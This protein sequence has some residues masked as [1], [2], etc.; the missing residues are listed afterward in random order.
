MINPVARVMAAANAT[1]LFN[2]LLDTLFGLFFKDSKY[3]L[4][5]SARDLS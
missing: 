2:L 4:L 5:T 1:F 3:S